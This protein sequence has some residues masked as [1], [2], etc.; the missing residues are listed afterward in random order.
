MST[1]YC[2][3]IFPTPLGLPFEYGICVP[4]QCSTSDVNQ[5]IHNSI[6]IAL[7]LTLAID[8]ILHP[9]SKAINSTNIGISLDDHTQSGHDVEEFFRRGFKANLPHCL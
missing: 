7:N 9:F 1:D 5:L 2:L 6:E 3:G 8:E 4:D